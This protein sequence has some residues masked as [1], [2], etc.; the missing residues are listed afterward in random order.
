MLNCHE[1]SA[2]LAPQTHAPSDIRH[3][4][5]VPNV[6]ENAILIM[7]CTMQNHGS[8]AT[9][10]MADLPKIHVQVTQT[11]YKTPINAYFR[12]QLHQ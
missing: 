5:D 10:A 12:R 4:I 7:M 8:M 3:P 1:K 2:T 9:Y 11:M 6:T